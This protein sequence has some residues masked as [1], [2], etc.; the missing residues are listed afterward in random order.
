[1]LL[2]CWQS[3]VPRCRHAM[4]RHVCGRPSSCRGS[5]APTAL[6]WKR[7]QSARRRQTLT[8]NTRHFLGVL[9]FD[10]FDFWWLTYDFLCQKL[11]HIGYS[12]PGNRSRRFFLSSLFVFE[13]RAR[14][15][16][17][18][19]RQTDRQTN[20]RPILLPNI[21][22]GL[23]RRHQT[24]VRI[25]AISTVLIDC[26]I[27]FAVTLS[28]KFQTCKSCNKAIT[29][30]IPPHLKCVATLPCESLQQLAQSRYQAA[31]LRPLDCE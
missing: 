24:I 14:T 4:C 6:R 29:L 31:S 12:S 27:F 16:R 18:T 21:Y 30:K 23:I 9:T 13:L 10:D 28:T 3:N 8:R 26:Q 2:L 5:Y 15:D 7:A 20:A 19:D 25:L 1:M 22:E 11:A 17:L